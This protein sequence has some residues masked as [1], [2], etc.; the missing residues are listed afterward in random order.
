MLL[1]GL[2]RTYNEEKNLERCLD[3]LFSFCDEVVI[4]DGGSTDRT[5]Y[6]AA[7]YRDAGHKVEWCDFPGGS[8]SKEVHFNHAGRQLNYG[9]ERC[10]GNW[11]IT[12]DVDTLFCERI[13]SHARDVL[14]TTACDAFIMYGVHLVVDKDHYASEFGTGPGL[15]QLFRNKEQVRFP[16]VPEH[17]HHVSDFAW[18]NLGVMQGGVFHFGYIDSEWEREK[19]A[20]RAVAVP[21]DATYKRLLQNP[22]RHDPEP[23][24]WD[25]CSPDCKVCWM[26]E[27]ALGFVLPI[28]TSQRD[29][30]VRML[31][32]SRGNLTAAILLNKKDDI[33][34]HQE[35]VER[36]E[37]DLERTNRRIQAMGERVR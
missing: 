18:S 7:R 31:D 12:Q 16:D 32:F 6:I 37:K 25:R 19:V 14:K 24:P 1:S 13:A 27:Q 9:L 10:K 20:L 22:S 15:V 2:L 11:V 17:A 26:E 29:T 8:I 28:L 35:S 33:E 4:S 34:R 3:N 21:E 5:K 36:I 23:V 30:I